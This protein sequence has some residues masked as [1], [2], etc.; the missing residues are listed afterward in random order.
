[1]SQANQTLIADLSLVL[2][3][4]GRVNEVN[5][6]L[7]SVDAQS[8]KPAEIIIVDQNEKEILKDLINEWQAKLS[9]KH[10]RV[11]FKGA[12]KSRNYGASEAKS[13]LIAFPDDDCLYPSILIEELIKLFQSHPEVDVILASK[14]EPSEIHNGLKKGKIHYSLVNSIL[15]LFKAK[16]ET[17][18]IFTRKS[19]LKTLSYV[20]DENIGPGA[21][22]PWASNEETDFLIRLL[23]QE[24]R[25]IKLKDLAIAHHSLQG[26]PIKSLK[27]GMGRF[28]VILKNQLGTKIYLI[29]LLQPIARYFKSP[30]PYNLLLC[31]STMLGRSGIINLTYR[32]PNHLRWIIQS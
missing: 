2:C 3:T 14:I 28:E 19:I 12:S 13:S 26:S 8:I 15:D 16:A 9:I 23:K 7:E 31:I 29:N 5:D 20:F 24:A 25:I 30:K 18:N 17:S 32:L 27:Y 22:T 6:F 4:Y 1:M 21:N 11:N 10:R